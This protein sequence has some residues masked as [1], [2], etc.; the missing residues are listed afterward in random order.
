MHQVPAIV[1]TVIR[2]LAPGSAKAGVVISFSCSEAGMKGIPMAQ[3]TPFP[4]PQHLGILVFDNF[5]PLDVW[6]FVE[7]FSIARF[8]ETNYNS[9]SLYPFEILVISNEC[10]PSSARVQP[11]PV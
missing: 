5:E 11:G 9:P 2:T 1:G 10:A 3:E 8:I 6:G 7:A 4:R